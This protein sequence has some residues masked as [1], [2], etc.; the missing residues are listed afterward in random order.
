MLRLQIIF[1]DSVVEVNEL[2]YETN[3]FIH[4]LS[5]LDTFYLSRIN[6]LSISHTIASE[7]LNRVNQQ[8]AL[9]LW[10]LVDQRSNLFSV[11][12]SLMHN[13]VHCRCKSGSPVE[14]AVVS[15]SLAT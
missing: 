5:I 13:M 10:H 15:T 14:T 8:L 2:R 9:M 12:H 6:V 11:S 4:C 1:I 3:L 7:L